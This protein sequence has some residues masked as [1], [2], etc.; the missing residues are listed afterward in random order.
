MYCVISNLDHSTVIYE[1]PTNTPL[2]RVAWNKVEE[3][4]YYL[5]VRTKLS[6]ICDV[7]DVCM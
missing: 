5:S 3:S 4:G 2:L 6:C 1:D 7:I